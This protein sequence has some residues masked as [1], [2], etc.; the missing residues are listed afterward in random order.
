MVPNNMPE[1]KIRLPEIM[2]VAGPNGSGKS[3]IT[4]LAK[5][6]GI[7]INAD[8]IKRACFC[9]DLEAAQKAEFLREKA[10]N[11]KADF[12]FETVLSTDRNI[13]L[14][15]KAKDNGYFIRGIY[16][17]T[18]NSEINV[19]RVKSRVQSGGHDVPEDKIRTRY[20]KALLLIPELIKICDVLHI[21]DNTLEPFR[22]F[23]K[24]KNIFFAWSNDFWSIEDIKQLTG[25]RN[26]ENI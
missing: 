7:Y 23:K 3:T 1:T 16:I 20:K 13:N 11:N 22:I 12:T 5:I 21:Y 10:V 17:L 9:S 2:F 25:I 15:K 19:M 18:S 4:K 8:D 24:R 6:V 26:Y 14:L